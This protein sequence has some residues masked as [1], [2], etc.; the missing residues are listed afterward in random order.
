MIWD[1]SYVL[2][3]RDRDVLPWTWSNRLSIY[4]WCSRGKLGNGWRQSCCGRIHDKPPPESHR[5]PEYKFSD[6]ATYQVQEHLQISLYLFYSLCHLS[7][8]K[9]TRKN[10]FDAS[11]KKKLGPGDFEK[12]PNF[13]LNEF[14]ETF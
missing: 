4:T 14:G 11:A 5:L 7:H 6:H 3:G 13:R 10:S 2:N 1:E 12:P 9:K 8:M